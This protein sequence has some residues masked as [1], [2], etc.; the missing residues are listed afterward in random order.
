M[1]DFDT[2]WVRESSDIVYDP[3]ADRISSIEREVSK[4]VLTAGRRS[5]SSSISLSFCIAPKRPSSVFRNLFHVMAG[6]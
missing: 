2:Y 5:V 1:V 3:G 6:I 4:L